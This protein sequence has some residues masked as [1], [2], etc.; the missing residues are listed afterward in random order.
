MKLIQELIQ[1]DPHSDLPV[2]IQIT[3]GFIRAIRNGQL[4][5][6]LKLPGSREVA[7]LL[8][9]N[10]MTMV[11]AYD[12]LQAQGWIEM[13]ARKGT[14]VKNILPVM[15]PGKIVSE[16]EVFTL[17]DDSAF[18]FNSER[19]VPYPLSDFP[20]T[21]KLVFNDGFPDPRLVPAEALIKAM[22]SLSRLGSYKK[23]LMYGGTQGTPALRKILADYLRD[24]RGLPITPDN[25]LITRGAQMGIYLTSNVLIEPGDQVIVGEPNYFGANLTFQQLGAD[26]NRVPVD[27]EGLDIDAIEQLCKIKKIRLVYVIPHHHNP[28]TVT[29]TPE[30]RVRLLELS[31][32]YRFAIIE[33]DY[34]YDFHYASKPMMPMASLDRHGNVIY[35]GTL[36]KTLAPAI[37]FG[38]VV[39]PKH[40]I[41]TTT[42][43]RKT[44]DTQGDA[45][46]ENALAELYKDGTISRHIKKSVK[47]YK[48]RRDHFCKLLESE[49]GKHIS[50]KI[51]DGGMSVWV[52]FLHADVK[53]IAEKAFKK[54]VVMNN[55]SDYDTPERSFNSARL[56]FASLNFEEQKQAVSILK[57][58][59][60]Q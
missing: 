59:L 15:S 44:V 55:G 13:V 54:G 43:L 18:P 20:D 48:E 1:I 53:Q 45:L 33:D 34:D 28:T 57:Q 58:C 36:T 22:R 11:A 51:P 7:G 12:E 35:I 39:A 47:L 21:G 37:R 19:I 32:K 14:F 29:L 50:F 40:F 46:M 9:V 8:G 60:E 2:Y 10:R 38:F 26:I 56:G 49:I 17:P 3:N 41:Q 52:R 16:Q 31:F 24:S 23:Y 27:E 6:G 42:R 25:I 30:R 4:R 5:K